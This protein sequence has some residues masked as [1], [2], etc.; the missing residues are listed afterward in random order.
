MSP[1]GL[2]PLAFV[3]SVPLTPASAPGASIVASTPSRSG[4]PCCPPT[5]SLYVPTMSPAGLIPF[6]PVIGVIPSLHVLHGTS[7]GVRTYDWAAL[8]VCVAA[9]AAS[10]TPAA[11]IE[12]VLKRAMFHLVSVLPACAIRLQEVLAFI[13]GTDGPNG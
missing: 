1:A 5:A 7:S 9:A 3:G 6:A 4:K 2:I 8:P 10:A 12:I 11:T 13:S